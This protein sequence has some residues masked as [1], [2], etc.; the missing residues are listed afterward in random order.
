[1][2]RALGLLGSAYLWVP[3]Q[4]GSCSRA[5]GPLSRALSHSLLLPPEP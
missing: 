1:M 5:E 4:G 2:D 3:S